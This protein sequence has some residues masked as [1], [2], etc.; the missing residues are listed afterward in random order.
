MNSTRHQTVNRIA[1]Q[2]HSLTR[3]LLLLIIA[4]ASTSTTIAESLSTTIPPSKHQ[5]KSFVSKIK[6]SM[7]ATISATQFYLYGRRHSTQTGYF[8]HVKKYTEPVQDSAT[9]KVGQDGADGVDLTNK[10]VVITGANSGIGKEL[11]TYAASKGAK[12]Y[13]VCRSK[14]RAEAARDEIIKATDSQTVDIVLSDLA[15]LASVRKAA[16]ELQSKTKQVDVL[17]CNGGVLLNDKQVSSEGNELTFASHLLGGSYLLSQ[18]LLPQLKAAEDP[19][20]IFVS[21]GGMYSVPFP[22]WPT[23]TSD[24]DAAK[25]AYDGN[26]AYAYAKR[27]QVLLA[28]QYTKMYPEIKTVSSH[29]GWTATPAVDLA[30][31][32]NKKYLEPMRTIW[33]GSEGIAWLMGTKGSN[34]EGGAFYLDRKPQRKHVSGPFMTDGS[35]TKNTPEQVDEMM[36]NLKKAAGL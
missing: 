9:I 7:G 24:K 28:E 32:D 26:L 34:L 10:V 30:Y 36:S 20:I 35:Y 22:D 1:K 5:N 31:G 8:K 25:H 23:A 6:S 29:P 21:S 2:T 15:E 17:V 14:D 4:I 27:G 12:L 16:E 3:V 19:R 33:Q 11:A 13:M 18:L